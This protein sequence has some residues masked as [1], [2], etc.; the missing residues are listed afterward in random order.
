MEL[1]ATKQ[2]RTS[3]W[4]Y[5]FWFSTLALQAYFTELTADEAYYWMYSRNMSWGYFD[6]PPIIAVLIK[7]GYSI[8][9][10][11]LGVRLFPVLF[12]TLTFYIAE[13]WI[14]PINLINYYLLVFSI[15]ILHFIGFMALPD[16]PFIFFTCLL[17]FLYKRYLIQPTL[18][19][20]LLIGV[21]VALM[22][23]SKYH[24]FIVLFILL[25]SNIKLLKDAYFWLAV[26]IAVLL[27]LP[28]F[29]WQY[30]N[31]FP[32]LVYHLFERSTANYQFTFTTRYLVDQLFVLGPLTGLFFFFVV[33][34]EKV[35]NQ[36][37]KTL[38]FLFWGAFIF[39]F[40]MSFKGR[41]EGHW[42]LFAILPALY[43]GT[44]YLEKIKINQWILNSLFGFSIILVF[45]SRVLVTS[46]VSSDNVNFL[47][48]VLKSFH[49][50]K[51]ML[52]I[53]RYAD[54]NVVGFMNSYQKAS[55]YCFYTK[56]KA[57]SLNNIMGRKNQFD[58]WG[59]EDAY[60]GK[61]IM[62]IPNYEIEKFEKAEGT[63]QL[64][65]FSYIDNFQY[66]SGLQIV[67]NGLKKD[68]SPI[69]TCFVSLDFISRENSSFNFESNLGFPSYLYYQF[70]DG[71][72][73][74]KQEKCFKI[75]NSMI[76]SIQQV[77]VIYPKKTGN[78]G[79]YFTIKTGW[80]PNSINSV[81]YNVKVVNKSF[82]N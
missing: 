21:V 36:F 66:F 72:H 32:A 42:T 68:V 30:N 26:L 58:L 67:A 17:I 56:S 13:K 15:G 65:R 52:A 31:G 3:I 48:G 25:L 44:R 63:S 82:E 4:F 75:T 24:S 33:A 81:R 7:W 6:H 39:F 8:F 28:H 35:N 55:L 41:V 49:N 43:F 40:F 23:L 57:F 20:S 74:Y 80:L 34:K 11:E 78:Y 2:L 19:N 16:S 53:H 50:K 79:L 27:L 9:Q 37:E 54:S 5:L 59:S 22:C 73:L 51:D 61:R 10:N 18:S 12:S 71:N 14:N 29:F 60:R 76:I 38:K 62:I 77:K 46:F 64:T 69:D 45:L 70:F 47:Q 1:S